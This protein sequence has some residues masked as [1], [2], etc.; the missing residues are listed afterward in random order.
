MLNEQL[1]YLTVDDYIIKYFDK[2]FPLNL[3][4]LNILSEKKY[5]DSGLL[6]SLLVNIAT[7]EYCY[8]CLGTGFIS[9]EFCVKSLVVVAAADKWRGR[10]Y[11]K[12]TLSK[13][14]L[15]RYDGILKC[16]TS[17]CNLA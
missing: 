10:I 7:E 1:T 6:C 8:I 13:I 11:S 15:S 12:G 3:Q 2:S 16:R 9:E 14:T 17:V 5:C 4:T